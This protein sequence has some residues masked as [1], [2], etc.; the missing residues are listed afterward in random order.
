MK[1]RRIWNLWIL[2][3]LLP[4][5]H[6]RIAQAIGFRLPNQNAEAIARGNAFAA[7]AD[8]PSAIYY[9]PAGIT[10][11]PGQNIQVGVLN[12]LGINTHYESPSGSGSDSKFE[13]L[14]VPQIH[15]TLTPKDSSFSFGLGVFA[16]FGLGVEWPEDSGFRSLAIESRLQYMTINPVI[17]WKPHPTLSIAAGPNLNYSEIQLRRGLTSST[18]SFKFKGDDFDFGFNAGILWQPH[19]QWSFGANYRSATTMNFEGQSEY[20]PGVSIPSAKTTARVPFPQIASAGISFRPTTNWNVEANVDW[21]DW[22]DLD[23][24][25][26]KGTSAIFGSDL[27][28]Q[29]NWHSSWM[30]EFG[31]T[32]RFANGWFASAGYFFSGDTTPERTFTPA[33]PD[34]DLHVGS[35][36]FGRRGPKWNWAIAGQIIAGEPREIRNSQPNPF[37]SESADGSYQLFV[38]AITI[39]VGYHF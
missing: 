2:G 16:P 32:R 3:L 30:Y 23:T 27:P 36:G 12:Y 22:E 14:P 35:L 24:V 5:L 17:A 34:T 8:N 9:N 7:T 25:V 1:H 37:T 29:L 6:P 38:P 10:Q 21:C 13:V 28:L 26:L 19:S 4:L 15:Y 33:V 18:D 31:V 39:N 11:L 20:D